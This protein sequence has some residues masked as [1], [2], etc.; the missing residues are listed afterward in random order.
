MDDAYWLITQMLTMSIGL[1]CIGILTSIIGLC[2]MSWYLRKS[3]RELTEALR[4]KG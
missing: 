2:T 1:G 3:L 4:N